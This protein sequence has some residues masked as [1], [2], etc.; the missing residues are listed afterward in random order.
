M[1]TWIALDWQKGT[2]MDL[3]RK[4]VHLK[5]ETETLKK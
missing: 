3:L 5:D 4:Y 1:A 2:Y